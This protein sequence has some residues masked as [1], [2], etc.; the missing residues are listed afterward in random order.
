MFFR[1][2]K[3]DKY[4]KKIGEG[5][6][7][8]VYGPFSTC[9]IKKLIIIPH[10]ILD[11]NKYYIIKQY[12]RK[13]KYV[14]DYDKLN[15]DINLKRFI[16]PIFYSSDGL[17]EIQEYGGIDFFTLLNDSEF[18]FDEIS[19][20]ILWNSIIEI[21]ENGILLINQYKIFFSDIKPEN[22]V[23]SYEKGISLIDIELYEHKI[24]YD[25]NYQNIIFSNNPYYIPLQFGL[26]FGSNFNIFLKKYIKF[27][28]KQLTK[29]NNNTIQNIKKNLPK[30]ITLNSLSIFSL[31]YPFCIILKIILKKKIIT[32]MININLIIN[33][34]LILSF[35]LQKR[36]EIDPDKIIYLMK[37]VKR[38]NFRNI[39]EKIS[40]N[41]NP[42][43]IKL[44]P[45][46][47]LTK[48]IQSFDILQNYFK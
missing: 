48:K 6:T 45:Q 18:Y 41:I 40:L 29:L 38:K 1:K 21:I 31:L 13:K 7:A 30:N 34:N 33:M 8:I 11:D 19:L 12:K 2:L 36:L 9:E 44:D 43:F 23:Y 35:I 37:N 25:C 28:N 42:I 20:L 39:F 17:I 10:N 3:K 24:I 4:P 22:M 26:I 47:T 15:K 14:F 16:I 32:E 27:W 5:G 46:I